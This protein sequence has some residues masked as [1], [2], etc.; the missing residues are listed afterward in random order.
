MQDYILMADSNSEI[1]PEWEDQGDIKTMLMPYTIDGKEFA[2]D[3]GR[4]TDIAAFYEKIRAGASVLTQQRNVE[5]F[6]EFWRPFLDAGQDI[7]YVAFSSQLSG[8][9]QCAVMA[10]EE[11]LTSY[12]ERRILLV[13]SLTI[14]GP[15]SLLVRECSKL[16]GE[17]KSIEEVRDFA[18][19]KKQTFNVVFGVEDL[20]YLKR[21]GRLTGAA[22]FFGTLLD[23]KPLIYISPDGRL[24]PLSKCKGRKKSL[25]RLA[26]IAC[27]HTSARSFHVIHA[28][29]MPEVEFVI[30]CLRERF[31]D[32]EISTNHLGPVTGAH[33]GPG[34]LGICYFADDRAPLKS[35]A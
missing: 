19:A 5:D 14:S 15:L 25:K 29:C 21:G 11:I 18:E 3:L 2:Y 26:E 20:V 32:A 9:F 23:V 31:P 27:D 7:L 12:P 1:T 16:R 28:D 33:A 34:T 35:E 17:G 22:A 30:K 6:K 10:R 13:D 4:N 24:I 8:T